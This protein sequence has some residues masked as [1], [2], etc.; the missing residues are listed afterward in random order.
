VPGAKRSAALPHVPTFIES[1]QAD[2]DV[3]SWVGILAPVKAPRAAVDRL[4]REIAGIVRADP[5]RER[6][7]TLGIETVGNTPEQFAEQVRADL[8]RW[9]KVVK[10]ANIRL[11]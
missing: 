4:Q 1:G 10:A 2:F 9:E 11:E 6:Y 5:V 8:A 7:L 3:T